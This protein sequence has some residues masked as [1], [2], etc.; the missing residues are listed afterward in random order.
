VKVELP[1]GAQF[2]FAG[3]LYE[4]MEAFDHCIG[5]GCPS[6][7]C[8]NWQHTISECWDYKRRDGKDV[9]FHKVPKFWRKG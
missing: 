2:E 3:E 8:W 4:V 9:I 7:E 1:I 5:C 6:G